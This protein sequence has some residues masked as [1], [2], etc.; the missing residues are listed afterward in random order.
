MADRFA[1]VWTGEGG[2]P[3]RVGHLVHTGAEARFT[4][5][6]EYIGPGISVLYPPARFNKST[7]TWRATEHAPI[8]PVFH[9]LIPPAGS[10]SGPNIQRTTM[11]R[12]LEREGL[13]LPPGL[14]TEWALLTRFGRGGIG[15]LDVFA[16]DLSA[17]HYYDPSNRLH[18]LSDTRESK[19]TEA[20]E[21]LLRVQIDVNSD[22]PVQVGT[23]TAGGM[24]HKLLVSIPASGWDGRIG[25]RDAREVN[26]EPFVPVVL[27]IAPERYVGVVPLEHLCIDIHSKLRDVV[28]R[29]WEARIG[30]YHGLAVE[31]FDKDGNGNPLALETIHAIVCGIAGQY[32][33]PVKRRFE[34]IWKAI[35]GQVSGIAP[36]LSLPLA[37]A[38][39]LFRRVT[40]SLLTGNGDMHLQN[41]SLQERNGTV[42]FS[43]LYDPAPMRAWAQ[44]DVISANQFGGLTLDRS[45]MPSNILEGLLKFGDNLGINGAKVKDIVIE[46]LCATADYEHKVLE[47]SD[48]RVPEAQKKQLTGAVLPLR[49]RISAIKGP[50][51]T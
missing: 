23:A 22:I 24:M 46:C 10:V 42:T 48:D 17:E 41:L 37:D 6:P 33:E 38:P 13:R 9:A 35:T 50:V 21:A 26:G 45:L 14:D 1:V 34:D 51:E 43:P 2:K 40:L 7:I 32:V 31:R 36:I 39:T 5:D 3:R 44:H 20:I 28:P 29:V 19:I 49:E 11:T 15:H 27:K 16:D 12:L 47:F 4:Y 25:P 18:W 8:H 30:H